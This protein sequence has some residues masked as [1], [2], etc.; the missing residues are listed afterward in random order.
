[1]AERAVKN[2]KDAKKKKN[3]GDVEAQNSGEKNKGTGREKGPG[4]KFT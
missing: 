4:K 3:N 2:E 1:M